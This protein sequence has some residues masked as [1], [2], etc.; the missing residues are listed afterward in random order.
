M[1]FIS[2]DYRLLIPTNGHDLVRDVLSLFSHLSNSSQGLAISDQVHIDPTRL[3]VA[4][5]SGGGI[6][7]RYAAL[8]AEPRPKG[9]MLMYTSGG[10]LLSKDEY[11]HV[12]PARTVQSSGPP[13][14][15]RER[16]TARFLDGDSVE[17]MK[18]VTECDTSAKDTDGRANLYTY[19]VRKRMYLDVLLGAE[20]FTEWVTRSSDALES[21]EKS[22]KSRDADWYTHFVERQSSIF[23]P[24]D[25][26]EPPRSLIPQLNL[27]PS[28]PPTVLIHGAED[29]V[30][31]FRDSETTSRQLSS[32]GVPNLLVKAEGQNHAFDLGM[33]QAAGEEGLWGFGPGGMYEKYLKGT[34]DW[35]VEKS[36]IVSG[37]DER[38]EEAEVDLEAE[39][40][41]RNFDWVTEGLM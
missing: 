36:G 5:T 14:E 39:Y 4:G 41:R 29:S 30:I 7:A 35:V 12:L 28:F 18:A 21:D 9:L 17:G 8:Y 19:L 31:G 24:F 11:L 15:E 27:S 1:A 13:D 32:L 38:A 3:L 33:I 25:L 20:G 23:K 10:D 37:G 26:A 34:L 2:S 22:R 6:P 16:K 40:E